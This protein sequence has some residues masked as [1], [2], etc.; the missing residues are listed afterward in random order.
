MKALYPCFRLLISLRLLVGVLVLLLF[1]VSINISSIIVFIFI[2]L[3]VF[4]Y[5]FYLYALCL[6]FSLQK[7]LLT[8]LEFGDSFGRALLYGYELSSSFPPQTLTIVFY[9]RDTLSMMMMMMMMMTKLENI[10]HCIIYYLQFPK[11]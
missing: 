6:S 7:L 3:I 10:I 5:L 4:T 2:F 1:L 9:E 8:F 11:L